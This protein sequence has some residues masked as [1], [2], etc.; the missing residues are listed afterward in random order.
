MIE[1]GKAIERLASNSII[2]F[3]E[4]AAEVCNLAIK[5]LEKQ[6]NNG[7]IPVSERLPEKT[8]AYLV[9]NNTGNVA[10][11]LYVTKKD[12]S[13]E[14]GWQVMHWIEILAWQPLPEPY[15]E[16]SKDAE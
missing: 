5:A 2:P 13:F 15:K 16:A 9:T 8:D 6:M 10:I 7:W 14:A 3:D 1:I 12:Y 11:V 4:D